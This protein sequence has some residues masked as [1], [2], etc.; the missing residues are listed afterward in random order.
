MKVN[1]I[2]LYI[3]SVSIVLSCNTAY[4]SITI[5]NHLEH[6]FFEENHIGMQ[7][8]FAAVKV[9]GKVYSGNDSTD[10]INNVFTNADIKEKNR[11]YVILDSCASS[12][13][14]NKILLRISSAGVP[15]ADAIMVRIFRNKFTAFFSGYHANYK[16]IAKS[17]SMILQQRPL[18]SSGDTLRGVI[19][20]I[21]EN[22]ASRDSRFSFSGP[23]ECYV[24]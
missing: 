14:G 21:F 23:F 18:K 1:P 5:D 7:F 6:S 13:S 11:N 10:K 19:N 24:K 9:N 15:E 12:R 20:L 3:F 2:F 22:E 16:F 4:R 17:S 8:R